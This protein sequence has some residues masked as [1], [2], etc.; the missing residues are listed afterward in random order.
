MSDETYIGETANKGFRI[1]PAIFGALTAFISGL[2]L[3]YIFLLILLSSVPQN[4]G[5]IFEDLGSGLAKNLVDSYSFQ[6]TGIIYYMAHGISLQASGFGRSES[7]NIFTIE[8][9]VNEPPYILLLLLPFIALAIGGFI[10]SKMAKSSGKSEGFKSGM[11]IAIPY[12]ILMIIASSMFSINIILANISFEAGSIIFLSLIEGVIFGG[13]GGAILGSR[14]NESDV[15]F[16]TGMSSSIKDTAKKI[17]ASRGIRRD[18]QIALSRKEKIERLLSNLVEL[19]D[20]GDIEKDHQSRLKGEYD[21]VLSKTIIDLQKIKE[22]LTEKIVSLQ[23]NLELYQNNIKDLNTRHKVGE[24]D[25]NSYKTNLI[26]LNRKIDNINSEISEFTAL[27]EAKT[28]EDVGG[29][30]DVPISNVVRTSSSV[31]LPGILSELTIDDFKNFKSFSEIEFIGKNGTAI[32]G[33]GAMT[34]GTFLP[35]TIYSSNI[36]QGS[37]IMYLILGLIGIAGIFM[38]NSNAG[39]VTLA[40]VGVVGVL[41]NIGQFLGYERAY[42]SIGY[43]AYLLGS[44]AVA[45]AGISNIKQEMR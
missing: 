5:N 45:Y 38:R 28:S 14:Q 2:I 22:R 31:Q 36:L 7:T 35:W 15:F 16:E 11:I 40:T 26:K 30:L 25:D 4:S 27:L 21:T 9:G 18:L 10:S 1:V 8:Q 29:H 34:I 13:I 17:T 20:K 12:T 6:I 32:I 19:A 41:F 24:L 42:L 43:Y 37:G 23:Q 3:S 44:I 39:N 33:A